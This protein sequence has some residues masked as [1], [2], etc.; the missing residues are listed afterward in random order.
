M[1]PIPGNDGALNRLFKTGSHNVSNRSDLVLV[2]Q[3]TNVN[4]H[5]GVTCSLVVLNKQTAVGNIVTQPDACM[6]SKT[7]IL[8]YIYIPGLFL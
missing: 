7:F 3:D 5:L 6:H 8:L 1:G 2:R 4:I